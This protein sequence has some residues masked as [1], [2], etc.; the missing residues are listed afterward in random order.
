MTTTHSSY[1][2]ELEVEPMTACND[3]PKRRAIEPS[4]HQ[5]QSVI[6]QQSCVNEAQWLCYNNKTKKKERV[7]LANEQCLYRDGISVTF[8]TVL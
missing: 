4:L 2:R 6:S 8:L 1:T 3:W 5:S 7:L